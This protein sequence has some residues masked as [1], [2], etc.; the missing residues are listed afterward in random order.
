MKH[1]CRMMS[2]TERANGGSASREIAAAMVWLVRTNRRPR[3]RSHCQLGGRQSRVKKYPGTSSYRAM[4]CDR[5]GSSQHP[6]N[7]TD[8]KAQPTEREPIENFI[9]SAVFSLEINLQSL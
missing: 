5:K 2:L 8:P 6:K 4:F 3:T 1:L 9:H 7:L